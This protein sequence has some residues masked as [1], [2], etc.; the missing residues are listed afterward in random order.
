[1]AKANRLTLIGS[2]LWKMRLFLLV[3]GGC[4]AGGVALLMEPKAEELV[5]VRPKVTA[6]IATPAPA[7]QEETRLLAGVGFD[8][9]QFFVANGMGFDLYDATVELDAGVF[10]PKWT[11]GVAHIAA[12]N[13]AGIP[14]VRFQKA[15]GVRF[16]AGRDE[17]SYARVIARNKAG[18]VFRSSSLAIKSVQ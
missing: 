1:M 5:A 11:A 9:S 6:V 10:S 16:N 3:A 2:G 17:V 15:N 8:G 13:G 14:A 18:G 4:L 12:N 7:A